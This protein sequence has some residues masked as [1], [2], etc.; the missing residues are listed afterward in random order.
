MGNV[1]FESL[2]SGSVGQPEILLYKEQIPGLFD[3]RNDQIH[4]LVQTE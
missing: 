4:G 3:L 2:C 1:K